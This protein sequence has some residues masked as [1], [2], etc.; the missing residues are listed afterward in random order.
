MFLFGYF[1]QCFIF[2]TFHISGVH[3]ISFSIYYCIKKNRDF[4]GSSFMVSFLSNLAILSRSCSSFSIL[5][6][7]FIGLTF[8]MDWILCLIISF[9][10]FQH[11]PQWNH[12]LPFQDSF[13]VYLGIEQAIES[14]GFYFFFFYTWLFLLV[15]CHLNRVSNSSQVDPISIRSL[16]NV[17]LYILPFMYKLLNLLLVNSKTGWCLLSYLLFSSFWLIWIL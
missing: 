13:Y 17:T 9:H 1:I 15:K 8:F 7:T 3:V 10:I 14:L 4:L 16:S 2:W 6:S 5:T 12:F 11:T